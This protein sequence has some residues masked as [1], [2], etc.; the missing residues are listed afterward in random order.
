[1]IS[2]YLRDN[3]TAAGQRALSQRAVGVTNTLISNH[4]APCQEQGWPWAFFM[5]VCLCVCVKGRIGCLLCAFIHILYQTT[6]TWR[7]INI[8]L[9]QNKHK[10]RNVHLRCNRWSFKICPQRADGGKGDMHFGVSAQHASPCKSMKDD[11]S[12]AAQLFDMQT[13]L[14]CKFALTALDT[15]RRREDPDA[16]VCPGQ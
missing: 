14:L 9:S 6:R 16:Q 15:E 10:S 5:P 4:T 12:S 11:V 8:S 2:S 1:M 7:L 3:C 13:A